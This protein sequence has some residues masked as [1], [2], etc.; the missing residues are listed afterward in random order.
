MDARSRRL[1]VDESAATVRQ[2]QKMDVLGE[3]VGGVTHELNNSLSAI[4]AFGHLLG[5]DERLPADMVRDANLLV[6]ET[7]RMRGTI[8]NLL[9]FARRS[10]PERRSVDLRGLFDQTLDLLAHS[11]RA[12]R[13]DVRLDLPQALPPVDVDRGQAQQALLNLMLNGIQAIRSAAPTGTIAVSASVTGRDRDRLQVRIEDDG[14][15]V[16]ADT[17]SNLFDLGLG[18]P[19]SQAIVNAHGGRLWFEPVAGG[20]AVFVMEL[21]VG[22]GERAATPTTAAED[23]RQAP[24][25]ILVIDDEAAIRSLL[26]RAITR[27]GH[28]AVSAAGGA[29][30]LATL[31]S[32]GH[33]DLLL[34]DHRLS[35]MDGVETY[36]QAVRL[37]A[38]LA[39]R[40]IIMSG[41]TANP[42]LHEFAAETGLRLLAK[43]F[44]IVTVVAAVEEALVGSG[45]LQSRG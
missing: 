13:I 11:L 42:V 18:L 29:E 14:P 38:D 37:R 6:H 15:G 20:G 27:A 1:G 26:E 10:R 45:S 8:Q 39:G 44:D 22:T 7:E 21:P 23:T 28:E 12:G 25:R 9:H 36:R 30:A 2:A 3:L 16:A 40:A 31:E 43:P 17:R 35:G 34:I 24:A 19:V 41:D 32:G 5:T 4:V 33:F